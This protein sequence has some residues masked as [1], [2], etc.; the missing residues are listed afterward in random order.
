[1]AHAAAAA[2]AAVAACKSQRR[3]S[4]TLCNERTLP[5]VEATTRRM[6]FHLRHVI[7]RVPVRHTNIRHGTMANLIDQAT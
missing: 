3:V 4:V 6:N 1:M 5:K 7:G 2:A